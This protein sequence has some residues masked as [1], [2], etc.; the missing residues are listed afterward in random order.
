LAGQLREVI[1]ESNEEKA[2]LE[3]ASYLERKCHQRKADS[4]ALR[5]RSLLFTMSRQ[6]PQ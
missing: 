2:F 4:T 3:K 5:S 1:N 6:K